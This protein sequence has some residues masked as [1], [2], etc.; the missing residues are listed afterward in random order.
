NAYTTAATVDDMESVRT[1]L[2]VDRWNLFSVSYGSLVAMHAMRARPQMIR[3]VI[4]NSPYPPNSV[5]WAEQASSAA[6]AY[7]AIDRACQAESR[8]RERFGSVVL[9]LEAILARLERE[10]LKDGDKVINGRQFASA[11]WPLAVRSS[12]VKFVP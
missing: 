8:C 7:V 5:T 6:A 4:L 12:T 11:L 9:K 10:P 1:A 2:A 3:S